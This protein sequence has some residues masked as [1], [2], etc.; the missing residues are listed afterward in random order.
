MGQEGQTMGTS[1]TI[2][3]GS[4]TKT[5]PERRKS[6]CTLVTTTNTTEESASSA[7]ESL[8]ESF[9]NNGEQ[10][11]PHWEAC[12]DDR[13]SLFLRH[14]KCAG[15][16]KVCFPYLIQDLLSLSTRNSY[17]HETSIHKFS[18]KF[19]TKSQLH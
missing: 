1:T 11:V 3:A 4:R 15:Y 2:V 10:L 18:T 17:L 7:F 16:G 8:A 5:F 12:H 14:I 9:A 19:P 6:T 13:L